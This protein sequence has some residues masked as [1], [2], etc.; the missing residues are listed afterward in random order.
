MEEQRARQEAEV[1]QPAA[2][3][4]GATGSSA[5]AAEAAPSVFANVAQ[6]AGAAG[7]SRGGDANF[8]AMTEEEQLAYAMQMS[9][10]D[11]DEPSM[12]AFLFTY[13]QILCTF[14]Y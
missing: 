6:E 12:S 8:A 14:S 13:H 4:A 3:A 9:L 10:N 2:A 5:P 1:R 11:H 7:P